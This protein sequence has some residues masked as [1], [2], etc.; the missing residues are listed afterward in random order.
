[1]S[2][3]PIDRFLST[4]FI[5]VAD[6]PSFQ[7]YDKSKNTKLLHN[8]TMSLFLLLVKWMTGGCAS[9]GAFIFEKTH[10]YAL[11]LLFFTS[12]LFF[13]IKRYHSF[14]PVMRIKVNG[15][16]CEYD[17]E[18]NPSDTIWALKCM[19][20]SEFLE[21]PSEALFLPPDDQTLVHLPSRM[22]LSDCGKTI[23]FYDIHEGS[24]ITCKWGPPCRGE[25]DFRKHLDVFRKKERTSLLSDD[26]IHGMAVCINH[27]CCHM[28]EVGVLHLSPIGLCRSFSEP[29]LC[30]FSYSHSYV[31]Y[32]ILIFTLFVCWTTE[33]DGIGDE[34][35]IRIAEGLE[36]NTSL[37]VLK[38]GCV[39]APLYCVVIVAY[40]PKPFSRDSLLFHVKDEGRNSHL[41]Y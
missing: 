12:S 36:K 22:E 20:Y 35:A 32:D 13:H 25:D 26:F 4:V 3:I 33:K 16:G 8:V 40:P 2:L 41:C 21:G 9:S 34:E 24:T 14:F 1:V 31:R 38:L 23:E 37:R 27:A 15:H 30:Y 19:I 7:V 29:P 17:I 10:S 18:V 11:L 28:H 5:I 39:F 6:N